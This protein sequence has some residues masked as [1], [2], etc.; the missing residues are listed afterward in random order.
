M[1]KFDEFVTPMF[2]EMREVVRENK[3]LS[4]IRDSILTKL[5]SGEID[6]SEI[7]I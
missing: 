1:D 4:E 3:Q 7:N 5:M 6:I 2:E